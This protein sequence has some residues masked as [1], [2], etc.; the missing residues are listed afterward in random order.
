MDAT[1]EARIKDALGEVMR[2][3][4]T[5]VIAHR[6]STISLADRVAVLEQGRISA[7]G[8]HDELLESSELYQRIVEQGL[9]DQVF[10]T[11]KDAEREEVG[12]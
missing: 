8:T 3:R 1:T 11:R 2:D 4:T 7:V 6:L 10:L 12:L 9:P 5:I